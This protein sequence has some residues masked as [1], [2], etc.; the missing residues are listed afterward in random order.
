[1]QAVHLDIVPD[2]TAMTF[3]DVSDDS[4][5]GEYSHVRL[6][7]TMGKVSAKAIQ[8]VLMHPEV[9]QYSSMVRLQ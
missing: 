8:T 7:Q 5:Q 9:K 3:L 1:M 6:C 2:L 4:P